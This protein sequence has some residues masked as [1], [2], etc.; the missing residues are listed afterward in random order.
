MG[1]EREQGA[2]GFAQ[3]GWM[4]L[5]P[6]PSPLPHE[7]KPPVPH[8]SLLSSSQTSLL[9]APA[10]PG[11]AH[12][13][14]VSLLSPVHSPRPGGRRGAW[15]ERGLCPGHRRLP[16]GTATRQ[17]LS[18]SVP[19][20]LGVLL[21]QPAPASLGQSGAWCWAGAEG[22]RQCRREKM[23]TAARTPPSGTGALGALPR[24]LLAVKDC[25]TR[26]PGVP[27]LPA[28]QDATPKAMLSC[29][30]V[31]RLLLDPT[32][33]GPTA[34][35]QC[36]VSCLLPSP[37]LR[38]LRWCEKPA[39]PWEISTSGFCPSGKQEELSSL[40]RCLHKYLSS[41]IIPGLSTKT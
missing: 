16:Q 17:A 26:T 23:V 2:A 8:F 4:H 29:C 1:L 35:P 13:A 14:L 6:T 38:R 40:V 25:R 9:V 15:L 34:S 22:A 28:L 19:H 27:Q 37:M 10:A 31:P 21:L 11:N 41:F 12:P 33:L 18:R 39:F 3:D 36:P 30:T 24:A 5:P 32:V 20:S 7:N